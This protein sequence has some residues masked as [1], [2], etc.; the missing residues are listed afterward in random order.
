MQELVSQE[1]IEMEMA[2]HEEMKTAK[3]S[4][5]DV[6]LLKNPC[7]HKYQDVDDEQVLCY[8]RNVTKHILFLRFTTPSATIRVQMSIL[9]FSA[10]KLRKIS[11][12]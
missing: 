8:Y 7:R 6:L 10:A 2:G 5:A 9:H 3:L 4:K 12:L 11:V 1:L